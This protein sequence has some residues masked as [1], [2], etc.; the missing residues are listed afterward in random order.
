MITNAYLIFYVGL[1]KRY[2]SRKVRNSNLIFKQIFL[3]SE[4]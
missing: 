1:H 4:I 3:K 2:M